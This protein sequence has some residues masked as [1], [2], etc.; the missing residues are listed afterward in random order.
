MT[1]ARTTS[2]P[3]PSSPRARRQYGVIPYRLARDRIEILLITS[4]NTRRWVVP[5]GWPI[6]R[7][8]PR[9]VARVEALE[10]AGLEGTLGQR[11]L[12]FFHYAKRLKDGLVVI[13]RVEVFALAV[14]R[15]LKT[16]A[17]S[18]ERKRRWFA[19]EQAVEAV[20]EDE[21][22]ALIAALAAD[23]EKSPPGIPR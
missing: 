4:R 6:G 21:L 13:C 19:A 2:E 17:E 15:Q 5:K 18:D 16:W 3:T 8:H 14:E 23:L 11:S 9:E 12:G 20:R 10:E 1:T 7:K 22:K